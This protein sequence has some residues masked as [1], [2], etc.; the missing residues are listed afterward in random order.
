MGFILGLSVGVQILFIVSILII[1]F[2]I[3]GTI[4]YITRS[5]KIKFGKMEIGASKD[6]EREEELETIHENEKNILDIMQYYDFFE[7]SFIFI[8][9]KF[10]DGVLDEFD[11]ILEHIEIDLVEMF[12]DFSEKKWTHKKIDTKDE[13]KRKV[14]KE[15]NMNLARKGQNYFRQ[16]TT[17]LK[18]DLSKKYERD[19]KETRFFELSP[20]DFESFL[21]K[22]IPV[23]GQFIEW[24]KENNIYAEQDDFKKIREHLKT[25]EKI[26]NN[27]EIAF[28]SSYKKAQVF[29]TEL[30]NKIT[31]FEDKFDNN[32]EKDV[33]ERIKENMMNLLGR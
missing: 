4:V 32:I 13:I 31:S 26:K 24:Y 9:K 33:L 2:A 16:Y 10:S 23:Y 29:K 6:K 18:H 11:L 20:E 7:E 27:L 15:R 14:I 5:S 12:N 28:R 3:L 17:N 1:V 8:F 19:F 22:Q 25:S 21:K 30:E